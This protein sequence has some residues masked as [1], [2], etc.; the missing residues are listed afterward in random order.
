M[1]TTSQLEVH[2]RKFVSFKLDLAFNLL[3]SR[4]N[5]TIPGHLMKNIDLGLLHRAF[6]VF[7]FDPEDGRL[8]LQQRADEK[9]T[10]P[11]KKPSIISPQAY[12]LTCILSASTSYVD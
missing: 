11:G 4:A 12:R 10:F 6:S 1:K 7:L 2:P 8:L 9:I 5:Q 3:G